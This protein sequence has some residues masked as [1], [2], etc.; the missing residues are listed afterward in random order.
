MFAAWATIIAAY[1]AVFGLFVNSR[2]QR[3]AKRAEIKS[4][5]KNLRSALHAYINTIHESYDV[6]LATGEKRDINAEITEEVEK[7]KKTN[8]RHTPLLVVD[9]TTGISI[10]YLLQEYAFL[11]S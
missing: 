9:Q 7:I 10:Q 5:R 3:S 6:D 8:G 1:I 2:I 11:E 4:H